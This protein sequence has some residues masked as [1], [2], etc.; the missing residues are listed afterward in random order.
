MPYDPNSG[1]VFN[2]TVVDLSR[3]KKNGLRRLMKCIGRSP[4]YVSP[5]HGPPTLVELSMLKILRSLSMLDEDSLS[6]V[7]P[8][9]L[10]KIWKAITRS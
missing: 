9:L 10:E 3:K 7:P 8:T 2:E 1:L 6:T 5:E 4:D